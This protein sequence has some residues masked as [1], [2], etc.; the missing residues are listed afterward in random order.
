VGISSYIVNV[1]KAR[2]YDEY[3]ERAIVPLAYKADVS[4]PQT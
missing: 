2:D 4:I 3:K 1:G